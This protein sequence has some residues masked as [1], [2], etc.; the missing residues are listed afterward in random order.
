MFNQP[1]Q[2]NLAKSVTIN[3][4]NYKVQKLI[5]TGGRGYEYTL[6]KDGRV[7]RVCHAPPAKC[8]SVITGGEKIIYHWR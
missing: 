6:V 4:T 3:D 5:Y 8:K 1:S 2:E 7:A